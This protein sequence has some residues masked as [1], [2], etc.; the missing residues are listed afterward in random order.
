MIAAAIV[1]AA[2]MSQAA[3]ITWGGEYLTDKAG[4]ILSSDPGLTLVKL[5]G[6]GAGVVSTGAFDYDGSIPEDIWNCVSGSYTLTVD[7]DYDGDKFAVMAGTA[8]IASYTLSGFNQDDKS[9]GV[10]PIGISGAAIPVPEPTSGLLLLLGV[11]G[12]ALRR[13]RA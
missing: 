6:I 1:C 4:K 8:T 2:V 7:K 9:T 13:R 3:A 11:A 12:M 10:S 5:T